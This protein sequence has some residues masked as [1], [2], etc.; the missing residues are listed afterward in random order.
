[1]GAPAPCPRPRSWR[2]LS[3]SGTLTA[4]GHAC[5]P[6][7]L[8]G[9]TAAVRLAVHW[10]PRSRPSPGPT[11]GA[12]VLPVA[13]VLLHHGGPKS[14]CPWAAVGQRAGRWDMEPRFYSLHISP[15]FGL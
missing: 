13:P 9:V 2:W 8:S 7:L 5:L 11:V 10:V 12:L 6:L 14:Q 4:L 3:D 15:S 1:M